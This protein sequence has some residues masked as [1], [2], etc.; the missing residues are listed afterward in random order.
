MTFSRLHEQKID[1]VKVNIVFVSS[2]WMC[3][4]PTVVMRLVLAYIYTFRAR[5]NLFHIISWLYIRFIILTDLDAPDSIFFVAHITTF[6][7]I[8]TSLPSRCPSIFRKVFFFFLYSYLFISWWVFV[9]VV[10]KRLI[11]CGH[12]CWLLL[13]EYIICMTKHTV[14]IQGMLPCPDLHCDRSSD[15]FCFF[16]INC[17]RVWRLLLLQSVHVDAWIRKEPTVWLKYLKLLI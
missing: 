12:D 5:I 2:S 15:K 3:V 10:S 16:L 11:L 8:C 14:L 6:P 9:S 7:F 13:L 4:A 17:C 1:W